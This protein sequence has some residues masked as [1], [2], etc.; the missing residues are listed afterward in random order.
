MLEQLPNAVASDNEAGR[1]DGEEEDVSRHRTSHQKHSEELRLSHTQQI[2]KSHQAVAEALDEEAAVAVDP[3]RQ[4]A[5]KGT[6]NLINSEELPAWRKWCHKLVTW[7][8]FD[9]FVGMII[10]ANG[11]TI[12]VDTQVQARIPLGCDENC[13]CVHPGTVCRLADPWVAIV[14]YAF[15]GIYILELVLRFCAFGPRVVKSN[16]VKFDMFLVASATADLILKVTAVDAE[17]LKQIML[18]RLLRLAR[19]AR[20]VRLIVQFQTLWKLVN[21][22]MSCSNT[23]FWTFLLM[24]ILSYIGALFG[25]DLCD[26]DL[27]LPPDHPYNVA[28]L[29]YFRGL[30]NSV[31]TLVQLFTFDSIAAIYRPLVQHRPWLFFYFM[32]VLLVLSIAL[33]NLVTA[34]MV[35]GALAIA[36][37]DKSLRKNQ[38]Q[39]KKKRQ[40]AQLKLMFDELDEDGSGELTLDEINSAPADV[41][42]SLFEIAGTEDIPTLFEMLDYDGGGTLET[43]EF[44]EGIFKASTSTKPL[45]LDR[46]MK[47]CRD[48]LG[49]SRKALDILYGDGEGGTAK[50]RKSK[51]RRSDRRVHSSSDHSGSGGS[52]RGSGTTAQSALASLVARAGDMFAAQDGKNAIASMESRVEALEQMALTMQRDTEKILAMLRL[53]KSRSPGPREASNF[54]RAKGVYRGRSHDEPIECAPFPPEER[55][56]SPLMD[57]R[58]LRKKPPIVYSWSANPPLDD[59]E[60]VQ[61]RRRVAQLEAEL[62]KQ[63]MERETYMEYGDQ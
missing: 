43:D 55:P 27:S 52:A 58:R 32:A 63:Q 17:F 48:I 23:L 18:V 59:D 28:A 19:L 12:G 47:Q 38:E 57:S 6:A 2:R 51:H 45:E 49:N 41:M 7:P 20:L 53:S 44:C 56:P 14:D 60:V 13:V 39:A 3:G 35:E 62:R 37:Q 34:I 4:L 26:Y 54:K 15:F 36:E 11:L 50:A 30:D 25:M 31:F 46:L 5:R 1:S 42:Q 16:W 61:L 33:M 10:L 22:L 24:S 40:M 21:G 29:E 9:S 8:G